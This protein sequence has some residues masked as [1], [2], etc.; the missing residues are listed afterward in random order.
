M[1][2]GSPPPFPLR[3]KNAIKGL[4]SSFFGTFEKFVSAHT[5][6]RGHRLESRHPRGCGEGFEHVIGSKKG[7]GHSQFFH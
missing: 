3:Y 5:P 4:V 2:L 7:H 6:E 1:P